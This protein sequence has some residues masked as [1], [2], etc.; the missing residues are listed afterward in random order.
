MTAVPTR[1]ET[2]TGN[3]C[4]LYRAD[5]LDL[6]PIQADAVISDP[7]YGMNWNTNGDRYTRGG[8]KW[9]GPV[10]GDDRPFDPLPWL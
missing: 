4:E 3:W 6:L 9:N 5:C 10:I 1:I 8:R 2:R 7:P